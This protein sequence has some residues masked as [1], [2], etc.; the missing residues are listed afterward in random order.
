MI[1][2]AT[3]DFIKIIR[4]DR[5]R[6]FTLME[7]KAYCTS[8][9]IVHKKTQAYTL[10]QN[11]VAERKNRTLLEWA[12]PMTF[13]SNTPAYLWSEA[14]NKATY[15][16]NRCPS[17]SNNGVTSKERYIGIRPAVNHLRIFGLLA[18]VYIPQYQRNKIQLKSICCFFVLWSNYKNVHV[19]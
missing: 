10:Y 4:A 14:I 15:L 19:I 9:S 6:E 11:G 17:R 1:E 18:Y 3:E 7:F 5:G 13:A 12:K 2:N 8:N 16:I